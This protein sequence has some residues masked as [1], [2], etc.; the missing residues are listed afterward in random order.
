[1][2][3]FVLCLLLFAVPAGCTKAVQV[4][5]KVPEDAKIHEIY[6]EES[7]HY[8]IDP[9][10]ESCF[11]AVLQGGAKRTLGPVDCAKLK[12]SL[13]EAAK[14]ITWVDAPGDA[15]DED[16]DSAPSE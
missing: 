10:T 16:S 12:A 4:S 14:V 2:L 5:A 8:V 1:M 3:R 6:V 13:P 11:L 7:F 9:R 15:A